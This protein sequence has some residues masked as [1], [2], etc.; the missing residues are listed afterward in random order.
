MFCVELT[1]SCCRMSVGLKSDLGSG[2]W[3][4]EI[5]SRL[6]GIDVGL[7]SGGIQRT[8]DVNIVSKQGT[9]RDFLKGQMMRKKEA[10]NEKRKK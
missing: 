8:V 7:L 10:K 9:V 1:K 6:C 5:Q 3:N 4:D 2:L